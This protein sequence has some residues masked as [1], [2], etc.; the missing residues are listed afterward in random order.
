[1]TIR[2]TVRNGVNR[3]AESLEVF[4]KDVFE[5]EG[6][7][8]FREFYQLYVFTWQA[9]YKGFYKAWHVVARKTVNDPK[10]KTRNMA[11]MNAGKMACAQ[12]ARYV[13]NERC[14]IT[15]SMKGR[16]IDDKTPDPLNAF[17]Q[18]VLKDNNFGTAFGDM[19]EKAFALGG[20]ALKEWVEVPKDK[21][22]NDRGPGRVRISYHMAGQFVPT[23]W[24]NTKVKSGLFISREARDGFYY[25]LV[26]WH[27]FD[28]ETYRVT[29]ELYRMP[30]RDA[31]EPQNILGWWYPLNALYPLLSPSTDFQGPERTFFQYIRPFGANYADDNSPLGMSIFAPAMDTLHTLDIIFDSFQREYVLGKKRIIAPARAMRK[32]PAVNGG[33]GLM[34]SYFDADDEVYQALATDTAE[35]LK[36][37]DNSVDLR[38]QEHVDGINANLAILCSQVGF[39]PGTMSF[40]A[41]RGLKTATEVISEDSKTFG[42]VK[43]NEN[44]FKDALEEMVHAIFD[45]AVRYNVEWEGQPVAQL[46]AGGYSVA[47]T[48]DDSIIQDR[49]ANIDEGIKLVGAQLMSRYKF[50]VDTLGY[51]P[52]EAEAEIKR[53]A[54][55]KRVDASALDTVIF[56]TAE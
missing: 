37:I 13:W 16:A 21:E 52:E 20:A 12:M 24:D 7:P 27:H 56:S 43:A 18:F 29:N 54:D 1:M 53:I 46:L 33:S 47:V 9:V 5:L 32:V 8:A 22:G 34:V 17:L 3:V 2:D 35:D 31:G 19:A 28:G 41:Q 6:V 50:M 42:T 44:G 55:E 45:L 36:I 26:E 23:A 14:S 25:S 49:A 10:G 48:F 11:T 4:R 30:Q 38:V 40:D 51:T 39:D 15:A